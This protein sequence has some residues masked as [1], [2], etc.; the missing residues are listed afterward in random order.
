MV[1]N[2]YFIEE[3]ADLK[4]NKL[5]ADLY[6]MRPKHLGKRKRQRPSYLHDFLDEDE[7]GEFSSQ[8]RPMEPTIQ[9]DSNIEIIIKVEGEEDKC[10]L[11]LE[12]H[13]Q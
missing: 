11:G 13:K 12:D 7:D 5:A 2:I 9:E 6:K 10:C 8:K 1:D 3:R 4:Q